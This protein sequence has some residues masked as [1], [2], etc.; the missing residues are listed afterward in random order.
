MRLNVIFV[1]MWLRN[2]IGKFESW[3]TTHLSDRSFMLILSV[4]IGFCVGLAAVIIKNCVH[5]IQELTNF[6]AESY[7]HYLYIIFPTVGKMIYK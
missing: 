5:Y 1:K 6:L 3:R 4:I 7:T 2:N